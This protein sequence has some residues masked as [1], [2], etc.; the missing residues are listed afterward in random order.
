MADGHEHSQLC[1]GS[2]DPAWDQEDLR[3][4]LPLPWTFLHPSFLL[5]SV[6]EVEKRN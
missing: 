5:F 3:W 1:M 6:K 2:R 4:I